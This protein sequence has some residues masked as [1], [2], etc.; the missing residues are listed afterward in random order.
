MHASVCASVHT[1]GV[2]E[3]A[4]VCVHTC[5]HVSM[6]MCMRVHLC[7]IDLCACVCAVS[8]CQCVCMGVSLFFVCMCVHVY[9]HVCYQF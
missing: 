2:C 1:L 9:V 7:V 8:V 6:L 3:P 4:C 5:L